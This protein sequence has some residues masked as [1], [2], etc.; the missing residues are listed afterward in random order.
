MLPAN[1]ETVND[2][3]VTISQDS[4]GFNARYAIEAFGGE[5]RVKFGFGQFLNTEDEIE[6]ESEYLRGSDVIPFPE[7]DRFTGDLSRTDIDDQEFKYKLEH[8][9]DLMDGL[10]LE[11]GVHLENKERD[12][13]ISTARLRL[14]RANN[15]TLST[16]A[17]PAGING[18]FA[19][20]LAPVPGGFNNIRRERIDPYVMLSGEAGPFEWETGLRYETTEIRIQDRTSATTT[21]TSY[22]ILLPSAHMKWNLTDQDRL[23]FSAAR[24]VRNPSFAFL[25][26]ATLLAELGDNDF[27]GNARLEPET[28][29]GADL[30][31]ERRL[32]RTGVVGVNLFYRDIQDLIELTSV[33]NASGQP[34][35][36]SA[37]AGT[38][39][40]Q[41]NNVGDGQVWGVEFDLSAPL[42]VI[43]LENTG[44]FL[45][46]SWL[47]S[48]VS[49]AFGSRRFN[50]QAESIFNVGFIHDM[51]AW[52]SSFGVTYRKQGDAFGRIVGEEVSTEYSADLEAFVEHRFGERLTVRLTGS[53]LLDASKD[54]AFDKFDTF[55][56]QQGRAFAEYELET[57]SAGPVFQL[58]GRYAF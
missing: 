34:V 51:P 32:G 55:A 57:E 53:N 25:S 9:R 36:G 15:S 44:V 47:D 24:T 40:I 16:V 49:D 6:D 26:P 12:T 29:W 38:R 54:E 52:A 45:N 27:R 56:D 42:T 30:G 5:T 33:L 39:V 21:E 50:D 28:A 35:V 46:Y 20:S 48:D 13:R 23:S 19:A 14:T 4:Y 2:N 3:N 31:Y 7:V 17:R 22:E 1:I 10:S 58:I 41:P 11:F 18:P 43:G 37:G 8:E